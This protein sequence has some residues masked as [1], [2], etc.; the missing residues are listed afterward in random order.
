[1]A[2][3]V[4]VALLLTIC[5]SSPP[6]GAEEIGTRLLQW[7][8]FGLT[9]GERV[10]FT[11]SMPGQRMRAG[12]RLFDANGA[13]VAESDEVTIPAGEFHSFDFDSADVRARAEATGRRQL[14][15]SCWVRV[16]TPWANVGGIVAT[17]EILA[18]GTLKTG[19]VDGASNTFL[20]GERPPS[21]PGG[22]GQDVLV[23]GAG[24]DVLLGIVPDQ[25]LRV[26]VA[27]LTGRGDEHH[28]PPPVQVGVWIL[29]ASGRVIARRDPV[30]IPH[31]HFRV[32]DF[33][34]AGL[35]S[36]GEPDSGRLQVR[37]RL[38]MPPA[39][40]HS[41]TADPRGSGLLLPSVELVD[42]G[43]GATTARICCTNNLK[44]IGLG[45]H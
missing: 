45:T 15:A 20:A 13:L 19:I 4:L 39:G 1:M 12:V 32:F 24:Q 7:P 34:R 14:R 37:V 18:P 22:G 28:D 38:V 31:D 23:G 11:L 25:T 42:N 26:T 21:A 5:L 3:A 41:F 35:P 29:D 9:H 17:Q 2:T 8:A 27:H 6:V 43:T 10:R 30:A 33:D 16:A 44:Q 40:P 36:P